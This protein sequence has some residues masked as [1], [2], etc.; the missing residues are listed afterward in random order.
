MGYRAGVEPA[1]TVAHMKLAI[2][3][4]LVLLLMLTSACAGS[5]LADADPSL[6][7]VY[8]AARAGHLDQAQQMMSEV[9]RDHPRSAKAHYVRAELYA[10]QRNSAMGRRELA[11]AQELD[12]S[13][14]FATPESVSA[15]ERK[16]SR[17]QSMQAR[18][19]DVQS[20]STFPWGVL[21]IFVWT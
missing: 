15:L 13:L 14:S 7:Q 20:R 8:E 1:R 2:N 19:V 4:R 9:L 10:E 6:S 18:S 16:L 21:A 5:A 12:P 17:A 3:S 11:I